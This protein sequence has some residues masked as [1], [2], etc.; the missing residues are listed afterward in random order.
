MF[1]FVFVF[2]FKKFKNKKKEGARA[3]AGTG[4]LDVPHRFL[5]A[6]SKDKYASLGCRSGF[7]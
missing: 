1:V 4:A 2:Y 3:G 6:G 5:L 7:M